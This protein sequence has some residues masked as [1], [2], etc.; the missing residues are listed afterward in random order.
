MTPAPG[1]PQ[2]WHPFT[3]LRDFAP[4]GEIVGAS[5]PWLHLADGR[6][7]IDGISSWWVN[8]HGHAHPALAAAIRDQAMAFDQ[9]ILAD[10]THAPAAQLTERLRE[11]LPAGLEHVFFSDDGSTAVEVALKMAWQSVRA[12]D[13]SRHLIVAFDGAYHGDTLGAMAVGERDLFVQP[14]HDL[15]PPITFLPWGDE[16]AVA[17]F[18]AEHGDRVAAT[19]LEPMVQCAGGMRMAPPSFLR[20]VADATQRAGALLI[21]DEVAV[22]FGRTGRMWGCEHAGVTP[23]LLTMSKGITGGTL[24]LGATATTPAVFRSFLGADKRSAFLHAHSYTGNPIACAVANASLDLFA[25]EGTVARF[26]A[27]S[28]TYAAHAPALR[29]LAGVT[30]VRWLGSILAVTVGGGPG[31][32]HDPIGPRLQRAAFARGLYLRP[33]GDVVYLMPPAAISPE[34]LDRSVQI[35]GQSI[36]DVM[37]LTTG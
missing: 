4:L 9:V 27:M 29:A 13:P 22:G 3:Q 16:A 32:Y 17:A 20:A 31:G 14:F 21:A 36:T 34:D 26:A 25:R 5:G 30:D 1:R 19:I 18:F 10:F 6:R 8:I 15:L 28:T 7:V 33:L 2:I 11:V 12:T 35:V 23:D 24:P 37:G